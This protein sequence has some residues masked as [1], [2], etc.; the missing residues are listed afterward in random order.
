MSAS[1]L[2]VG[3][4]FDVHRFSDD[5]DRRLVLGGCTFEGERGLVGHS[6]ADAVAHAVADA[7]LG[8]AG[9]GDIGQRFPDT[10]PRWAGADS[11]GIAREVATLLAAQGWA[12]VNVDCSLV[13]ERPKVLPRRDEM[14]AILSAAVGAPVTVTG[15]RAEGLGAIGR[16]EGV[17]CFAVALIER[18]EDPS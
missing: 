7:L 4:G 2:R 1:R 17:A 5:P 15:R 9:L 10:D 6:D 14:Q 12:V 16:V 3:Q 11:V 13:C 18:V 8:A